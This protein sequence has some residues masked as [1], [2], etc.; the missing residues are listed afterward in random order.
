MQLLKENMRTNVKYTGFAIAL[1]WP[2]TLCKQPGSWYDLPSHWL[3]IS[4]NHFYTVGHA[5][6]V[7]VDF[8]TRKCHYYDFGRYHAPFQYGR[9]RS[10]TT[11]HDLTLSTRVELSADGLRITNMNSILAELQQNSSCH[12]DGTLHAAYCAINFELANQKALDLQ[13]ASPLPYG[14]FVWN[15]TNCSRFVNTVIRAGRPGSGIRFKLRYLVPFTPTPMNNVEALSNKTSMGPV[16]YFSN[17]KS[18]TKEDLK[19]TLQ[20]PNRH[21]EIPEEAQWLS[22]EGAG[23]WFHLQK[24]AEYYIVSRYNPEGALECE[25]FFML[26]GQSG[27]DIN[28]D[29]QFGHLSHCQR[30]T[31]MQNE[32]TFN[33]LLAE[34]STD[35]PNGKSI[36]TP[37]MIEEANTAKGV[38]SGSD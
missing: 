30:V 20:A 31:L 27:F 6:I 8:K 13:L 2:Q 4:K 15:G 28:E 26:V 1:A 25:G 34:K 10:K 9:A 12:G 24:S 18:P 7:L 11:D 22:G 16:H 38:S 23:S 33:L 29:Y 35:R 3:G 32:K 17:E 14:P 37:A 36:Q 5:A 19:T 21:P